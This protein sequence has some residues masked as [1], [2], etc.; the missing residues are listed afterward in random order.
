M[1]NPNIVF[2][3]AA[4]YSAE[5]RAV[6][7][8]SRSPAISALDVPVGGVYLAFDDVFLLKNQD[9][10]HDLQGR[11][12]PSWDVSLANIPTALTSTDGVRGGWGRVVRNSILCKR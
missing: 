3:V 6:V 11:D 1:K 10:V 9:P 2:D 12:H 7:C 4:V 8:D 5:G